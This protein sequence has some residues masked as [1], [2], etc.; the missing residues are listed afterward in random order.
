MR[1][2]A[3]IAK[4][5]KQTQSSENANNIAK[6][7]V[8]CENSI[9]AK[10]LLPNIIMGKVSGNKIKAMKMPFCCRP[11]LNAAAKEHSAKIAGVPAI[12]L[13]IKTINSSQ[14]KWKNSAKKGQKRSK[15]NSVNSQCTANLA[16]T[17]N[18][19]E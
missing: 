3:A 5:K 10:L 11:T 18:E 14:E 15:G 6:L 8:T 19:V 7:P 2:I 12:K 9:T 1:I 13:N 17:I 4:G 16:V